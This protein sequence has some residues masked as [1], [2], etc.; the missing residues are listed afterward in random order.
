MQAFEY[1]DG[2]SEAEVLQLLSDD[3]GH[4]EVIAGG[5]DLVGLMRKMVVTPRRVVH[6]LEAVS[7]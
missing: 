6:I 3:P 4:T 2:H 5:T 7:I 1:A